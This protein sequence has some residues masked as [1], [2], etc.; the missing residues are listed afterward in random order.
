MKYY[1]KLKDKNMNKYLSLEIIQD[2]Q[3][4]KYYIIDMNKKK[5]EIEAF[6]DD[7]LITYPHNLCNTFLDKIFLQPED[8]IQTLLDGLSRVIL[9]LNELLKKEK[10]AF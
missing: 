3:A 9:Y 6:L 7:S 1:L 4:G 10:I 2:K 5:W 8:K